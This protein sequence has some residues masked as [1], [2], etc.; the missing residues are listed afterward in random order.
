MGGEHGQ[1]AGDVAGGSVEAGQPGVYH[2]YFGVYGQTEG[3][4]GGTRQF[5]QYK[6]GL[7]PAI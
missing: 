3:S 1:G 5:Y 4:D 7:A 2:V 6:H